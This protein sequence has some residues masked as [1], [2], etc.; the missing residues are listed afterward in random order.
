MV[1]LAR[2]LYVNLRQV[3][4]ILLL[5]KSSANEAERLRGDDARLLE[6][7][8]QQG[9]GERYASS[10]QSVLADTIRL[11]GF[12]KLVQLG[13]LVGDVRVLLTTL[14]GFLQLGEEVVDHLLE[15][16]RLGG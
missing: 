12:L 13:D 4:R 15:V 10:E 6:V 9:N 5:T 2:L 11:V 8:N 16:G 3:D 7:E 14:G 1:S